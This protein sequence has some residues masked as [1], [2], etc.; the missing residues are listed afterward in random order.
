[1]TRSA[2]AVAAIFIAT[3]AF[4]APASAR[5]STVRVALDSV[6]AQGRASGALDGS[7]AFYLDGAKT[8]KTEAALGAAT[9]NRKTNAF[10]KSDEDACRWVALTAL[11]ALQEAAKKRGAN[12][13]VGLVS[14]FKNREWRDP[15][16]FECHAG[17]LM[18]GVAFKGTYARVKK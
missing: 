10:N 15:T 5:D 2:F 18:A 3:A 13:V 8:P 7:V 4:A 16:Q 17:G 9:V 11:A 6:V 12:A 14:N 1:M